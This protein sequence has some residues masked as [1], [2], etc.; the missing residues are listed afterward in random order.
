VAAPGQVASEWH[1]QPLLD[2][3]LDWEKEAPNG[4]AAELSPDQN[5]IAFTVWMDADGDGDIH[6]QWGGG[7]NDLTAIFMYDLVQDTIKRLTD[8]SS[9]SYFSSSWLPD[10]QA[11]AYS[12]GK[13]AY[14]VTIDDVSVRQLT[15]SFSQNVSQVESSP[16][17]QYLAIHADQNNMYFFEQTTNALVPVLL[18][19]QPGGPIRMKWSPDSQWFA[20]NKGGAAGL[21]L[22]NVNTLEITDLVD[23]GLSFPAWSPT[24]SRLVFT[25]YHESQLGLFLWDDQSLMSQ[26]LLEGEGT[27]TSSP[28]WS[29]DGS[30]IAVSFA[31]FEAASLYVIEVSTGEI[32][33]LFQLQS[34]QVTDLHTFG[35]YTWSPDGEWI[36]FS[37][38]EE[39]MNVFYIINAIEKNLYKVI[40]IPGNTALS[41][42]IFWLPDNP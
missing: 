12:W 39:G 13:E 31:Q 1:T 32:T 8:Y 18:S 27:G 30:K 19:E 10:N 3:L 37:N 9:L 17:G 24:D 4:P 23:S 7:G 20:F 15:P 33:E 5:K 38:T 16:D 26:Q 11:L 29:P 34:D 40:E 36:L 28:V 42:N 6:S 35:V 41:T 2:N 25:R 22:V 14:L 21:F